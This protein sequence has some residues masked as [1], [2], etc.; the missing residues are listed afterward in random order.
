MLKRQNFSGPQRGLSLVE[1]MI[2]IAVGLFIVAA[3][4]TLVTTQLTSNRK[5]LLEVQIQQD[6]RATVDI[7]TRELRRAGSIAFVTNAPDFVWTPGST[8]M[9]D[10]ELTTVTA[11]V[12]NPGT[13]NYRS[14]RTPGQNGPYG[15]RL[16]DGI[17]ESELATAGWQQLT[18]PATMEVTSFVVSAQPQPAV[19]VACSKLCSDGSKDCWPRVTVRAFAIDVTG[20]SRSDASVV[21]SVRS[22]VRLKNDL[23][24]TDPSL[25][26]RSCPA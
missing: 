8:W 23:V 3:A 16:R 7:M 11:S 14:S 25:G 2:G 12:G 21:R 20:R 18:D 17:I 6:L 15:F 19:V 22:V 1:L 9:T 4:A 13:V 26:V 24:T 10:T 5:L